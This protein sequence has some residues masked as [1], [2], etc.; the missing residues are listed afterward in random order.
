MGIGPS[1]G[2]SSLCP[3]DETV[4]RF[5][6]GSLAPRA[7]AE[8]RKHIDE[9]SACR[10]LIAEVGISRARP[11]ASPPEPDETI[12]G[13]GAVING[14]YEVLRVLG[15]GGM[16]IVL[17]ARHLELGQTVA[18]KVMHPELAKDGDSVKRFMREGRAAALLSSDHA[19]RIHDVGRLKSGL[20]FLVMEHLV[21]E[22]LDHLRARRTLEVSEVVDFVLQ[23]IVAIAEAHESGLVHRDIKPQNLFLAKL[24]DG[25][26]RVKVL[27]FGLAKDL[28]I[29]SSSSGALTTENMILG[30]PHFMSP[31]Q[32]RTPGEV[33]ARADVWGLGASM[34]MLLTGQPPYTANN[35][36][37]LLARILADPAPKVRDLRPDVPIAIEKIIVRCMNKDL[38]RRYG[39]VIELATALQLATGW[40][41]SGARMA[42]VVGGSSAATR[43]PAT[44]V[45]PIPTTTPPPATPRMDPLLITR[46]SPPAVLAPPSAIP[47]T[48]ESVEAVTLHHRAPVVT[49]P[50]PTAPVVTLASAAVSIPPAP[51]PLATAPPKRVPRAWLAAFIVITCSAIVVLGLAIR[52]SRRNRARNADPA[53][54]ASAAAAASVAS[55]AIVTAP[56][57][58]LPSAEPPI[59]APVIAA[60]SATVA[61]PGTAPATTPKRPKP[62]TP[63]PSASAAACPPSNPY[64]WGK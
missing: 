43:A 13:P 35:V 42:R 38:E 14:K 53:P 57:P 56:P 10:Q 41:P 18:I 19:V 52:A 11:I 48:V 51:P 44:T 63:P 58:A 3:G 47:E 6:G 45:D 26:S 12:L 1:V 24:P 17:A 22:D 39:S 8:V 40:A 25:T 30:S 27:D 31:E 16:G 29:A 4:A 49:A 62:V 21:G 36:H 33:D 37:G 54:T 15:A 7:D 64:C 60:P 46:I 50:V 34:V 5:A 32:I 23:A 55:P 9:C 20:P 28:A 59:T 61:L 2:A